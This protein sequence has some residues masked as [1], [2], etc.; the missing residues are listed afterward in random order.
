MP[1][2]TCSGEWDS[3]RAAAHASSQSQFRACEQIPFSPSFCKSGAAAMSEAQDVCWFHEEDGHHPPGATVWLLARCRG[4]R[5]SSRR[6]Q[7]IDKKKGVQECR[8]CD[9]RG[10]KVEVVRMGTLGCSRGAR[11]FWDASVSVVKVLL[12]AVL[13]IRL[14]SHRTSPRPSPSQTC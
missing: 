9:G 12:P 4:C 10:V 14:G 8:E 7:V 11:N 3:D 1:N 2:R 5:Q 13:A 6:S